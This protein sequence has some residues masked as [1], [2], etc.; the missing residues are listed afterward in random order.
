MLL[1]LDTIFWIGGVVAEAGLVALFVSKRVFRGF[2]VFC[3]Y[4]V[5]SLFVDLLVY[6]FRALSPANYFRAYL[7]EMLLDSAFQFAV[8]V[9]LGWSV[10]RP[11]RA[12]LPRQSVLVLALLIALLAALIW[13]FAGWILPA[14]KLGAEG[15]FYV[16]VQQTF[17]I[18][19]VVIFLVLAGFSQML[20]LGWKNREL[21]IATGLGFYSLVSLAVAM[22]H[23]HQTMGAPQYLH[24][25]QIVTASYLVSLLYWVFSFA[26]QEA[27][28]QEFTPQMQTFLLA[29]AGAAKTTRHKLADSAEA[30]KNRKPGEE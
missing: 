23:A 18:L 10:L 25:D 1:G 30:A 5:W 15:R 27:E 28:R 16:H 11:V 3:S 13:P 24:L 21:Q 9:E 7:L 14:Y 22:M 19:R 12:L 26:Q 20:S 17:A 4:L 6:T 8:L 29:V 2:P